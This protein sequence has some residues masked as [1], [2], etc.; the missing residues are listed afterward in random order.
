LWQKYTD[1]GPWPIGESITV[2]D[3]V[4]EAYEALQP[5][6]APVDLLDLVLPLDPISNQENQTKSI[7]A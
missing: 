3:L 5:R 7:T 6:E 4:D 2:K 1:T